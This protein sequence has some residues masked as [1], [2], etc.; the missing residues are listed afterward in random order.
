MN[1][2]RFLSHSLSLDRKLK[3]KLAKQ[4][5]VAESTVERWAKGVVKPRPRIQLQVIQFILRE[6]GK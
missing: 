1:F 5:E 6:Q 3:K 2:N 4:F